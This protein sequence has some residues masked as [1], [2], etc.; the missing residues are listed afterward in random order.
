MLPTPTAHFRASSALALNRSIDA[1]S[2]GSRRELRTPL[3]VGRAF[4]GMSRVMTIPCHRLELLICPIRLHRSATP[5]I[6]KI[7][8]H[9]DQ[10]ALSLGSMPLHDVQIRIGMQDRDDSDRGPGSYEVCLARPICIQ[11][12]VSGHQS[13]V[14]MSRAKIMRNEPR[15]AVS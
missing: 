12:S 13:L 10:A 8:Q 15:S 1:V 2:P 3:A 4:I 7:V 5:L 14:S 6:S 11:Y 9:I